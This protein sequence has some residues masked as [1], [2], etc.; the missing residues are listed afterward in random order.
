MRPLPDVWPS[1]PELDPFMSLFRRNLRRLLA[2]VLVLWSLSPA[3]LWAADSQALSLAL[4]SITL[5]ELDFHVRYL[6]DDQ[7]EG[8]E[9]GTRGG[10]EAGEYLV[11]QLKA[12]PL[13]GA[14]DEGGFVQPF[15]PN[16]RNILAMLPGSDPQLKDQY[17]VL[18]AHYDHLGRGTKRNSLGTVGQI[19][20]GADDNASGTS[21]LLEVAQALTLLPQAP[22]RSI[23]FAFWD[24][25][26]KGLLGS[27]Q[28]ANHP[29]VP[30][31]QVH[32]LVNVDMIGR[33]RDER[34]IVMGSRSGYGL[35]RLLS[36]QNVTT[37]LWLDFPAALLANADHYS[38]VTHNIP[39]L[40]LHTDTH[41]D[42][43]R[44]TDTADRVNVDGMRQVSQLLVRFIVD[45]AN[46]D[47]LPPFREAARKESDEKT[48][49]LPRGLLPPRLGASWSPEEATE[50]GVRL[51]AI[52]SRSAAER[53]GLKPGDR[54]VALDGQ[55]IGSGN[56]LIQAVM[57]AESPT[58]AMVVPAGHEEP[59]EL[60][61]PLEGQ[62]LRL[63][64][65]WRLDD[66]EPGVMIL[67]QIVPASAAEQAGLQAEDRVYQ[68]EGR[69]F[70]NESQFAEMLR[71]HPSPL[72]LLIE[73]KGRLRRVLIHLK[74]SLRAG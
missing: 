66:A 69:D 33:L 37:D 13:R 49:L 3:G 67:S 16:F 24:A 1:S 36:E 30:L 15:A 42:Y 11:E 23:L 29:T 51:R 10:R 18:S 26:E 62:P 43:H 41:R 56:Q 55:R 9:A 27:G 8:R 73:R 28:W 47:E 59:V 45:E 54:I 58:T 48:A 70:A 2:A 46:R 74:P 34:L 21:T 14:G 61:V 19:H 40:T 60:S 63:G 53:A 6:A 72:E 12:L 71:A 35:R 38:F 50:E 4:E 57:T 68:V 52:A 32:L 17:L 44:P 25:E 31:D 64:V 5:P 7:R 65:T 20:N 39:S 22:R